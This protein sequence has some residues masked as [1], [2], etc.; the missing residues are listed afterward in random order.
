[1]IAHIVIAHIGGVP[2]E[3][4]LPSLVGAGTGLLMALTW[5]VARA[6]RLQRV[7]TARLRDDDRPA[8]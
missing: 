5:A 6:R 7:Y 3:E 8:A 2:V 1:V 4:T